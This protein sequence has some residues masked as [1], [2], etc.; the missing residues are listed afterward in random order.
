MMASIFYFHRE[1]DGV[2]QREC[3][4]QSTGY[5]WHQQ[6]SLQTAEANKEVLLCRAGSAAE[7]GSWRPAEVRTMSSFHHN[8]RRH[9][10]PPFSAQL[11][12]DAELPDPV[13]L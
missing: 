11:H 8:I 10:V 3:N 1:S 12:T 5:L 6:L 2:T 9:Q 13:R 7:A 4:T